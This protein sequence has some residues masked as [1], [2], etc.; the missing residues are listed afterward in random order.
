MQERNNSAGETAAENCQATQIDIFAR[1]MMRLFDEGAKVFSTLA[2]R[3]SNSNGHGPYSMESEV[4]EAAKTL[5]EVAGAWVSDPGKLVAA[6]GELFQSYA[7]LWGR[8]FRRF[9]GEEAT[10]VSR[11]P[12]GPTASTSISGSKAI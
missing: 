2:E 8:S 10:T 4:G 7:D 9:L 3:T 1:N 5:G 11:T 12:I 6:Q